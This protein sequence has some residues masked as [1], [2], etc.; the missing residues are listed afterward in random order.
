MI[1]TT[2][3][4]LSGMSVEQKLAMIDTIWDSISVPKPDFPI[5]DELRRELLERKAAYLRDPSQTVTWEEAKN[6]VLNR[7]ARIKNSN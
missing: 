3:P 7:D 5:S 6:W 1:T 2:L 4:D